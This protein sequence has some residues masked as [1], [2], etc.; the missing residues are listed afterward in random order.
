GCVMYAEHCITRRPAAVKALPLSPPGNCDLGMY[1]RALVNEVILM[2]FIHH[3]NI[4]RLYDVQKV[5]GHLYLIIEWM[6]GGDLLS[7]LFENAKE[8]LPEGRVLLY[9]KQLILA[10][11][12]CHRLS[13]AH[14][15]IKPENLLLCG[16]RKSILKLADMGQSDFQGTL[17]QGRRGTAGYAAPEVDGFIKGTAIVVG[18]KY[19]ALKADIWSAGIVLWAMMDDRKFIMSSEN[20]LNLKDEIIGMKIGA[21]TIQPLPRHCRSPLAADLLWKMLVADPNKRISIEGILAHPWFARSTPRL[22]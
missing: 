20:Q 4:V 11:E 5:G 13:I 19:D 6:Q 22:I 16:F 2:R 3:P 7:E 9:F 1:K 8:G 18:M 10:L 12:H 21:D 17:L 15:D 14:C